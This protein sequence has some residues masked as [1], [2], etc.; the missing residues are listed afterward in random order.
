MK[1][2]RNQRCIFIGKFPWKCDLIYI[3]KEKN[4]KHSEGISSGEKVRTGTNIIYAYFL[5]RM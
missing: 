3:G 5:H 2:M 1:F 4:Q